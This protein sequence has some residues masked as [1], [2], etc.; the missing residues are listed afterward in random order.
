MGWGL[1]VFRHSGESTPGAG[2]PLTAV[3]AVLAAV[4]QRPGLVQSARLQRIRRTVAQ[5]VLAGGRH[6][7]ER[8]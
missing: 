5:L 1:Q 8:G 2:G 7:G 3:A 4:V 6:R